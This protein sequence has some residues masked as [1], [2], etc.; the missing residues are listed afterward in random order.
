MPLDFG[1]WLLT[2]EK[3]AIMSPQIDPL[4]TSEDFETW[5]CSNG[6]HIHPNVE[7][8]SGPHGHLLR[9]KP[10]QTI[11]PA[12]R[13][14]SCPHSLALSWPSAH[15][16]HYPEVQL[17][18]CSQHVVTRF[19]LMK[20]R[21][22]GPA[23]PWWPYIRMFPQSFNT[24]FFYG[25]EDFAWIRGTNLGRAKKVR[26]EAWRNEYEEGIKTLFPMEDVAQRQQTWSWFV[27]A[28]MRS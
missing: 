27:E 14:I 11:P 7:L 8:T 9:V 26:E 15:K 6:G 10:E 12:S 22:L 3:S 1:T 25:P 16:F 18:Q 24:P 4:S 5:F 21:L 2:F 19:F 28:S 20:Q 17:P 23:S 13:I